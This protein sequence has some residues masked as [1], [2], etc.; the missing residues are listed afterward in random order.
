MSKLEGK[1]MSFNATGQTNNEDK[2]MTA[3]KWKQ[4]AIKLW[5]LLD[6][7]STASDMFKPEMNS[8]YNYTMKKTEERGKYMESSDGYNLYPLKQPEE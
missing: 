3:E 1:P 4:I 8:F 6:D 2:D 7:I 5:E